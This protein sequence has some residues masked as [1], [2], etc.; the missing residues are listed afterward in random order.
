MDSFDHFKEKILN[1]SEKNFEEV[2]LE[3]FAYQATENLIYTTYLN[4]LGIK[5]SKITQIESIPFL[6]IEFFKNHEIKT[7]T[8]QA[9]KVFK[10]SGTTKTGR[11][12]HHV[13]NLSLYYQ[14]SLYS[15]S[16]YFGDLSEF[17]ICGL[18]PSYQEQ[19]D[20]SLIEMVNYF[21]SISLPPSGFYLKH[22]KELIDLLDN[23]ENTVLLFGVSYAL[24][25]L[26]QQIKTKDWSRHIF[27]ETG[28]MKGRKKEITREELHSFLGNAF[29]SQKIHT[30]YGMTELMS[31]AYGANG[32][33]QF[34]N[35]CKVLLRDLN[36][37]FD[38]TREGSGG[39]NVIDLANIYS[40]AFVETADIGKIHKNQKF[41]VLG[42]L[43]NSDIRGCSLLI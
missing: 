39:L 43:D 16:S 31:Q 14:L 28:G 40:C 38:L 12:K 35:W 30:E 20:S 27:I 1:V 41:E 19:G 22:S 6:P 2:A 18:L 10:S 5:P 8:W 13:K 29:S 21:S 11:S 36:D 42:R 24:I 32:M 34:P 3:L 15:A 9:E 4:F 26:A 23:T 17:E 37:P 25:D 7:G 33:L